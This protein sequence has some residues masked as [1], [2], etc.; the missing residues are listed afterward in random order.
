MHP[1][2]NIGIRAAREGG[3]VITRNIDRV[4]TLK[5]DRKGRNDFVS[6]VDKAAETEIVATLQRSF[7]DHGILTEESGEIGKQDGEFLWIIDPLDGTTNFIHAFPHFCVSIALMQNGRLNQAVVYDPIRQEL[8]TASHGSGAWVNNKR[9]RVHTNIAFEN[10]LIGSG[11]PYRQGQNLDFYMETQKVYTESTGGVRR[12]GS[13]ALDLAY[14]GAGRLDGCWLSGLKAWD[15]AAGALIVREAGGLINDYSGGD[16]YLD[17]GNVIAG[18]PKV[19]HEML[20]KMKPI[21]SEYHS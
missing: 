10:A 12:S 9:L 17:S 7:P 8:F 1:M 4:S 5:I 21:W 13:A 15:I 14:V 3:K 16:T 11:F 18:S 19:H 2:L 6:E 20:V